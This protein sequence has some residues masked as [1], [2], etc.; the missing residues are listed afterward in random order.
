MRKEKARY[1]KAILPEHQG[2]PLIEALRPKAKQET[3]MEAF[4]SYPKLDEHIRQ[5]PDPLVRDEYTVRLKNLRQ[6]LPIYYKCFRAIE[7]AI[8]A[9]YP[10]PQTPNP[11]PQ[12]P[13]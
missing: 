12:T 3:V 11:K 5:H 6:P 10:K 8:K 2:N 4:S 7:D 13:V 9:G 1:N